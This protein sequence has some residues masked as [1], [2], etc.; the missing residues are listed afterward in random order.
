M[1]VLALRGADRLRVP[2]D[3]GPAEHVRL[4]VS[5]VTYGRVNKD[6]SRSSLIVHWEPAGACPYCGEEI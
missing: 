5:V 2:G 3:I 1:T 6:G 4:I